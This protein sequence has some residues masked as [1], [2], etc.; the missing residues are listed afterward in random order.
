MIKY[1][2]GHEPDFWEPN[3]GAQAHRFALGNVSRATANK[4]PL[5]AICMN[6]SNATDAQADGTVNRLIEASM[7]HDYGGWIMLNLYPQ[8]APNAR[9]LTAFDQALSDENCAAIERVIRHYGVDE[10]LGAWGGLKYPVL[11][12]AKLEVRALLARLNVRL[13][14]WDPFT[15]NEP[16]HPNPRGVRLAMLGPKLYLS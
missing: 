12:T 2:S 4:P 3:P 5:I 1:L 14:T 13:F 11:R 16:R 8:R 15:G 7:D 10:V 6:P 9:D